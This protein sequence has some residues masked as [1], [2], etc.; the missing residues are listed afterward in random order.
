MVVAIE[1]AVD[2]IAN[3]R[4]HEWSD[5]EIMHHHSMIITLEFLQELGFDYV[6]L[7]EDHL[8]HNN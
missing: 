4:P 6:S 3:M 2:A 5:D 8:S 7:G 1:E